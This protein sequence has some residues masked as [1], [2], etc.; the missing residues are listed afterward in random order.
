M[1]KMS[2]F[3]F[4]ESRSWCIVHEK[5]VL[6][7]GSDIQVGDVCKFFY[8]GVEYEGKVCMIHGKLGINLSL[9]HW[10]FEIF[11]FRTVRGLRLLYVLG[12]VSNLYPLI[13]FSCAHVQRVCRK[14]NARIVS[15]TSL[16]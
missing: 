10:H 9:Y 14:I 3:L 1:S 7:A 12:W 16:S 5:N 4:A 2:W 13:C 6:L 11:V 15:V 8:Q